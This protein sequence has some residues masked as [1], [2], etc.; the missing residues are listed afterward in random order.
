[1]R[2]VISMNENF[3]YPK[4]FD[5]YWEKWVDAYEQELEEEKQLFEQ[6]TE[7]ELAE[8]N[9]NYGDISESYD[10][11]SHV[12]SIMTPFGI[13]PL[14]EQ[15]L[16]SNHFKLWVG[17]SNFKILK[18]HVSI[19]GAVAGVETVDILTPYRFRI[20]V[21]KLFVDRDVMSDVRGAL[22]GSL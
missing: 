2:K 17:H 16:A 14:T 12:R 13:M 7:E 3:E 6:L 19:I 20:S 22:L 11:V 21:A 18:S 4:G 8:L 15:S 9:I 10:K 5:V 1:V